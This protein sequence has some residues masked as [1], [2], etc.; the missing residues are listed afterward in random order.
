VWPNANRAEGI[1]SDPGGRDRKKYPR[2]VRKEIHGAVASAAERCGIC[3]E[4]I[5]CR[6]AD[7]GGK[8]PPRVWA[9]LENR[10]ATL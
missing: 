8:T 3:G 1:V 10:Y 5:S 6:I 9:L 2:E 7:L 4:R